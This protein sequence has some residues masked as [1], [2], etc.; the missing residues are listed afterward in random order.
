[1]PLRGEMTHLSTARIAAVADGR[2]DRGSGW[3]QRSLSAHVSAFL[4]KVFRL[5]PPEAPRH[6]DLHDQAHERD[7][8]VPLRSLRRPLDLD[9]PDY[10]ELTVRSPDGGTQ[11]LGAHTGCLKR[12][13]DIKVEVG[14][15]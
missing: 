10:V 6:G 5:L 4:G 12:F 11:W 1:V 7:T 2:A 14:T 13:F 15:D 3:P 9:A 8:E